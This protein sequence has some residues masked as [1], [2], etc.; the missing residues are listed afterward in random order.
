[1]IALNELLKRSELFASRYKSKGLNPNFRLIFVLA[2]K[3]KA[4][5]LE[6]EQMRAAQ[7][8]LCG[9]VATLKNNNQPI[10]EV[11]KQINKNEIKI[12]SCKKQLDKLTKKINW[13]LSK[14]HNLPDHENELN[15]QIDTEQKE[16]SLNDFI[17]A[18]SQKIKLEQTILGI[19][20][21]FKKN[22]NKLLSDLPQIKKCQKN[23][24]ILTA[25]DKIDAL[26][27]DILLFLKQNALYIIRYSCKNLPKH[28][29]DAYLVHLNKTETIRLE[30]VREFL[31][32]KHKIKYH[33]ASLD[34][35]KF[36]NQINIKVL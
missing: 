11:V 4:K 19:N 10:G 33:D 20:D 23:Y 16:I 29:A 3:L 26:K 12:T 25:Y 34:T 9:G 24:L 17:K 35:T 31:T 32:R 2:E 22:S 18:L 30:I 36:V 6:H 14:L 7:S 21:F 1:M 28:C 5:S 15:K 8:K 27:N 13:H